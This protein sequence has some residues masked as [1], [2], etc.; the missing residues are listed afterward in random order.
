MLERDVEIGEDQPFGHQRDDLIDMRIGIDIVEPHPGGDSAELAG[1]IGHVRHDLAALPH[2]RFLADIHAIS[3]G[4]LADDQQL[5]G[6]RRDQLLRLL[7]DRVGAPADEIAAQ[8]RDDAEGAAMVAAF[9]DLQIAVMAGRQ[10]Q[11][12]V[13]H[14]VQIGAGRHRRGDMD[15]ADHLLILVRPGDGEHVGE[16]LADDVGFLA[17][18]AGDDDAAILR[19]RLADRLQ[20]LFLGAVEEAAGVDQH[21]VRT[22]VVGAHRIAVGAQAREDALGIDQRL[23]AAE[24]DHADLLRLRDGANAGACGCHDGGALHAKQ[25]MR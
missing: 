12:R 13:G 25:T 2:P 3:R 1:E 5:L 22:C 21:H 20:A 6:P 24:R 14:Q 10:L 4:V 18:A 8:A 19:D 9:G 23:G 16:A 17:E 7:E 11:P 15:G